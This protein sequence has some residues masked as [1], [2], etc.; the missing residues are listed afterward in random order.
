MDL[1][2]HRSLQKC[3]LLLRL[4]FFRF[5]CSLLN[6]RERSVWR[7]HRKSIV[8]LLQ[9]LFHFRLHLW[10]NFQV[11]I[12]VLKSWNNARGLEPCVSVS[13]GTI[14]LVCTS[15]SCTW[16]QWGT[17]HFHYLRRS[18]CVLAALGA[19]QRLL[20]VKIRISTDLFVTMIVVW[21]MVH[22]FVNFFHSVKLA[23][24]FERH[25]ATPNPN[26]DPLSSFIDLNRLCPE[27]ILARFYSLDWE[28][29]FF[30]IHNLR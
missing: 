7:P 14:L 21:R 8:V 10:L 16:N 12:V 17:K 5:R 22:D 13:D 18:Q 28:V 1:F 3:R 27:K 9:N 2:G 15:M 23:K 26:N 6:M 4:L 24:L 30:R 25:R 19:Y 29:N 20:E 11:W